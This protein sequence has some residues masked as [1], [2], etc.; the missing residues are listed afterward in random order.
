MPF[1]EKDGFFSNG[2]IGSRG[3]KN[4]HVIGIGHINV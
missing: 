4:V 3:Q 2:E 1:E